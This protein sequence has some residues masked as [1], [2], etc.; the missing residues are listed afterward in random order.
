MDKRRAPPPDSRVSG[1]FNVSLQYRN[2][3]LWD[4]DAA[5]ERVLTT[6]ELRFLEHA[7]TE[8]D[9]WPRIFELVHA[10]ADGGPRGKRGPGR[11]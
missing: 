4:I 8:E 6:H 9:H 11:G 10:F 3:N 1:R 7:F 5:L 2:G